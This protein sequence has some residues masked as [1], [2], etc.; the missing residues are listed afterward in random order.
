MA[1]F[2]NREEP[3]KDWRLGLPIHRTR[4]AAA[5]RQNNGGNWMLVGHVWQGRLESRSV[6]RSWNIPSISRKRLH[7]LRIPNTAGKSLGVSGGSDE[8]ARSSRGRLRDRCT[9]NQAFGNAWRR[10]SVSCSGRATPREER[11]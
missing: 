9:A 4:Q 10:G 11:R 5:T 1:V 7:G 2:C 3:G 8:E 6:Q